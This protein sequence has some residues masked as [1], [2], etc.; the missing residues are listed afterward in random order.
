MQYCFLISLMLIVALTFLSLRPSEADASDRLTPEQFPI[1]PWGWTPG[2]KELIEGIKE[3]G[4]NLA[5]FV[6]PDTVDLAYEAGLKSIVSDRGIISDIKDVNLSEDEIAERVEKLTS[7]VIDKPGVFGYYLWDEPNTS[8]FP[9]LARWSSTFRKIHPEALCYINLLPNYASAGQL[10][11]ETYEQYLESFVETVDPTYISYDHYALMDDGSLR[12]GYFQNLESARK[13]SL[14]HDLPF[15][16]IILSNSHFRYADPTFNGLRFQVYTTLAYGGG[17]I[18]YFTYFLSATGNYRL[19]PIDQ[20][21]NKTPTWDMVRYINMQ[22]HKLGPTYLKLK[23]LNVFHHP[24]VPE[25]C[26]GFDTSLHLA[27]LTGGSFLVGEFEDPEGHPFVMVVNK[28]LHVSTHFDV[29]FKQEGPIMMTNAY[30]GQT[31]PWAGEQ[32]W[33][34]PGQGM[35]LSVSE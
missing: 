26:I 17:G 20:F 28:D 31:H 8:L 5:G 24:E 2:D 14:L 32:G 34:A 3:C 25:Q 18:S 35:L 10:G 29:K 30:T 21:R 27:E 4:F 23:S 1:L 15:W 16:N 33:L 22:I 7:K 13:V 19:A 11:A 6:A 9:S 12:H